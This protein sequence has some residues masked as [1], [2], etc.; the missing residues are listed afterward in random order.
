LI[1]WSA[2][3]PSSP[4]TAKLSSGSQFLPEIEMET[5]RDPR[6]ASVGIARAAPK[7]R[8][9]YAEVQ[10]S[11]ADLERSEKWLIAIGDRDYLEA[12]GRAEACSAVQRCREALAAF[13]TGHGRLHSH[14]FSIGVCPV[15]ADVTSSR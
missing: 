2:A 8:A 11:E 7:D 3:R 15:S 13:E 4:S 6:A 1:W 10:E 12:A 14:W 9:T 5:A